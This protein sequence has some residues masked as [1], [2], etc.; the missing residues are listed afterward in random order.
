MRIDST[1]EAAFY[2]VG[3]PHN[4]NDDPLEDNE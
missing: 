2:Q 3:R 1:R 4:E